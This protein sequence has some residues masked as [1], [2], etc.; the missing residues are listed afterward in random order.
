MKSACYQRLLICCTTLLL[1]SLTACSVSMGSQ[2]IK[3]DAQGQVTRLQRSIHVAGAEY[4][5]S[6]ELSAALTLDTT[7]NNIL[8]L[9]EQSYIHIKS[10]DD[11]VS[12]TLDRS[13][14]E[15]TRS[16]TMNGNVV[17]DSPESRQQIKQLTLMLFRNT[18]VEV[19]GRVNT[20]LATQG[21]DKVL[22][23]IGLIAD[24]ETKRLYIAQLAKQAVLTEPQQLQLLQ[25]TSTIRNDY[26]LTELLLLQA[27]TISTQQ[28]VQN[29]LLKA[30]LHIK[31]DYEKRR[32]LSQLAQPHSGFH[33]AQVLQASQDIES[34]Y[35]LGQ[36]L[37]QSAPQVRNEPTLA[38]VLAAAKTMESSYE[39]QQVLRALPFEHFTT[40]QNERVITMAATTI[41]SDHELANLF[42]TLLERSQDPQALQG[43]VTEALKS[44]SSDSD[45]VR[46][47]EHFYSKP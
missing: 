27:K 39:L 15:T 25:H 20:L 34:D 2:Y 46:V 23:E 13:H 33:L 12:F 45:K 11:S 26:D 3:T 24:Q 5:I 32:L 47:F 19:Q 38:A 7:G 17:P 22:T 1:L 42:I 6:A 36:L 30:T 37:Q 44:I 18:P 31:S 8:A 10:T 21:P 41:A 14:A 29:S 4:K 35:E 9:P 16:L 28:D 40:A 43:A